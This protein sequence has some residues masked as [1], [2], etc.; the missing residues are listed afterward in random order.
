LQNTLV[1][2]DWAGQTAHVTGQAMPLMLDGQVNTLWVLGVAYDA[3]GNVIGMRRWE[4][5]TPAAGGVSLPFE[6]KI[7]SLGP[8][9]DRVD[10]LVEARP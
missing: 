7:S 1:F 6:F 3:Q 4:S 10:L 8:P 5:T 9:I 2:V